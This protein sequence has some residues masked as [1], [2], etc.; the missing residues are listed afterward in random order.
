MN[1]DKIPESALKRFRQWGSIGGK[2]G[3]REA[4]ARAGK[5]GQQAMRANLAKSM[6]PITPPSDS[7]NPTPKNNEQS[8][9]PTTAP[10]ATP[11]KDAVNDT[12]SSSEA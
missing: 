2:K 12:F 7:P 3:N 5:L 10:T 9:E 4:K 11:K 8:T 1:T 6:G